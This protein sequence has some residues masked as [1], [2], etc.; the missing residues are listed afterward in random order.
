MIKILATLTTYYYFRQTVFL[1]KSVYLVKPP[2]LAAMHKKKIRVLICDDHPGMRKILSLHLGAQPEIDL[3]GICETGLQAIQKTLALKPDV[4]MLDINMPS[5][6]GLAVTQ[7]L[8][9]TGTTTRIIGFSILNNPEVALTMLEAG[10][11][12]YITKTSPPEEI[13]IAIHT[14]LKGEQY[15]CNEIKNAGA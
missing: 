12:G 9:Q 10:A 15:I 4:L 7:Q 13:M 5:P 1:L 8:T 6:D 2:K 3:L 14:V 11:S